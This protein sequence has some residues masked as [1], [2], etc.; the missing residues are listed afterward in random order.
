[1]W[2]CMVALPSSLKSLLKLRRPHLNVGTIGY[3]DHEKTTLTAAITK[4][5]AEEGKAKT[6]AFD[7]IDKAPAQR[8]RRI[9]ISIVK[10]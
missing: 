6:L 5:L 2:E 3:V 7:E 9:T 4:V 1:M 8:Q 10:N